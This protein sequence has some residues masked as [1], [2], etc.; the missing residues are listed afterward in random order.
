MSV[1][2]VKKFVNLSYMCLKML[3]NVHSVH[4]V[5]SGIHLLST[6]LGGSNDLEV[7]ENQNIFL[8]LENNLTYQ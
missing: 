1:L 4:A 6:T 8:T 2:S 5:F 3:F 7:E